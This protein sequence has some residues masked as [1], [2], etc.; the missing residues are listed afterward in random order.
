[1]R[2]SAAER[3]ALIRAALASNNRFAPLARNGKCISVDRAQTKGRTF[4]RGLSP[5]RFLPFRVVLPSGV[6]FHLTVCP[7]LLSRVTLASANTRSRTVKGLTSQHDPL[8]AS[9]PALVTSKVH[10]V[11][12]QK[13]SSGKIV[14]WKWPNIFIQYPVSI[15]L[16]LL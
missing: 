8:R 14:A 4:V 3:C 10:D 6:S 12:P 2:V 7:V 13:R 11:I 15:H 16:K 9:A 1:M 5:S